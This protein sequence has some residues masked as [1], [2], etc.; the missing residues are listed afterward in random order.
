MSGIIRKVYH[1]TRK[2]ENIE[3]ELRKKR[4][5]EVACG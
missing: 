1:T 2:Y 3:Y 5:E 4:T